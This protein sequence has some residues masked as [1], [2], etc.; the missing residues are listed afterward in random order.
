[1]SRKQDPQSSPPLSVKELAEK[2]RLYTKSAKAP[3]TLRA[4]RS[5]WLQFETWCRLHRLES[6]PASPETVALFITDIASD[7]A[8]ATKWVHTI[9]LDATA[10][11]E[12]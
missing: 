11:Q 3:S 8:V 1:M 5:D 10:A 6:L 12:N 9:R 7:H 2:A 4:Y